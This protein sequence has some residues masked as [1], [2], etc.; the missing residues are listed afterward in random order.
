VAVVQAAAMRE[1][2]GYTFMWWTNNANS[3]SE[4]KTL[5]KV[6]GYLESRGVTRVYSMNALL[7]WTITFYSGESIIARWKGARDRYPPYI[8]A[9]DRALQTG[10]PVAIV[11]Y[12]GYTYGLERLVADPKA[13]VDIDGKYFVYLAPD[14]ELLTRAGFRL[15]R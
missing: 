1:F 6:I 9:V 3:P 15:V 4:T 5:K 2:A 12:T 8:T 13:I 14:R 7:E 10:R 11:G